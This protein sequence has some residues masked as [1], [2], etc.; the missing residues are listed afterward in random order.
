MKY[1]NI[2]FDFDGT[3]ADT[4]DVILETM[5]RTVGALGLPTKSDA[6]CRAMIG[7]RLEEI[8]AI[9]WP[10]IPELSQRY[11]TTYREIFNTIKGRFKARL[12]PHV[13][14]TLAELNRMGVRM[15]IASSRSRA[16]LE[17]YC[18]EMRFSDFFRILVG[19]GDVRNGKPAPDP[20][21][22][23]LET[24]GWNKNETLVVGDM[25]VD[26]LMGKGAGTATCGVTYGNGTVADMEASGAD[27]IISDFS[28][29]I[30]IVAT[31]PVTT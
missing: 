16:S 9:L 27:H 18:T 8:P 28:D 11:V 19:G 25:N 4:S 22:L 1:R 29:L 7:Y 13:A 6:E 12:F 17:E 26:I 24:Q 14:Q 21:N 23:I 5:R 30:T 3:L 31:A 2:I 15:A 20:V 10:D